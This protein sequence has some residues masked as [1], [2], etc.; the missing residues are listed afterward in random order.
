[1]LLLQLILC[2]F[3][4]IYTK[5]GKKHRSC[6]KRKYQWQIP[7]WRLFM[8]FFLIFIQMDYQPLPPA[9]FSFLWKG[10]GWRQSL[11]VWK[12]SWLVRRELYRRGTGVLM[13]SKLKRSQQC[14]LVATRVE[15][16]SC[17]S[18]RKRG[19]SGEGRALYPEVHCKTGGNGDKLQRN[20]S[21]RMK[22]FMTNT[23]RG[24]EAVP[25]QLG[26]NLPWRWSKHNQIRLQPNSGLGLIR[27][28]AWT[29]AQQRD[30]PSQAIL[31]FYIR[32]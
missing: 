11:G 22:I 24:R 17:N 5:G 8:P 13:G 31:W 23:W 28:V 15:H 7:H 9:P 18:E 12:L 29:D 32:S 2:S 1:M 19:R 21:L 20:S 3:Q 27:G 4:Q 16:T 6:Y 10:K 26:K 30:L 14:G 25:S